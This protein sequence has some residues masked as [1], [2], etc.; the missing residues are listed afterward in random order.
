MTNDGMSLSMALLP[1][2][3]W[4]APALAAA[5]PELD[6]TKRQQSEV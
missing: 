5:L 3:H 6:S 1:W 4:L 2:L